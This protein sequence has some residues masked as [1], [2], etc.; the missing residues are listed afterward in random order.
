MDALVRLNCRDEAQ[1]LLEQAKEAGLQK[2]NIVKLK[3]LLRNGDTLSQPV[4]GNTAPTSEQ[5]NNLI[6]LYSHGNFQEALKLGNQLATHFPSNQIIPNILGAVLADLGKY[7]EA[8]SNYRTSIRLSPRYAE[9]HYNLGTALR[10]IGEYGEAVTSFEEAIKLMLNNAEV[11]NELGSTLK[12]LGRYEEAVDSFK[13]A[14]GLTPSHAETHNNLG[15]VL[16]EL[17]RLEDAVSS[18]VKAIELRPNY[19]IANNNLGN[20]LSLSGKYDEA[21]KSFKKTA[22]LTTTSTTIYTNIGNTYKKMGMYQKAIFYYDKDDSDYAS[23]Q[24]LQCL[25]II[26]QLD[27]FKSRLKSLS[28]ISDTNIRVAAISAFAAHQQKY[29]DPYPFCTNPLEFIY[30]SSL[31]NYTNDIEKFTENVILEAKN[32]TLMWQPENATTV[33]GFQSM[34]TIFKAGENCSQLEKIILKEIELYRE[35]FSE[36]KCTF[37]EGWPVQFSLKGWFVRLL[38]SGHQKSHIHASGWLSGVI[39]LKTVEASSE[40][41]G[42]LELGLHGYDLPITNKHYPRKIHQPRLGDIILFPSSLFHRTIPFQ[43][44][45]E[46][47]VIAF[48]LAPDF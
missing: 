27:N 45:S 12:E 11:Y 22:H 48:D 47:C 40:N 33:H 15:T 5:L 21:I 23:A 25:Y 35:K 14:I 43:T 8:I 2:D 39:Y 28:G 20:A 4:A 24:S 32:E 18:Y 42:A 36:K 30:R 44:E 17:G 26:G 13:K 6:A 31:D 3:A 10:K 46:R 19:A 16:Q 1:K 34:P 41:E 38:K 29:K 7:N 9:A 37:I